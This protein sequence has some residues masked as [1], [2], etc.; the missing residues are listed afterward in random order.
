MRRSVW[1]LLVMVMITLSCSEQEEQVTRD[2][3]SGYF[4]L[5]VGDF[6]IYEVDEIQYQQNVQTH[7]VYELKTLVVDSFLNE[8]GGYTFA[9]NQFRR[10]DS[11]K[12]WSAIESASARVSNREVVVNEGNTSYV[13]MSTPLL[14][15]QKWN[16]NA[17]NNEGGDERCGTDPAYSCDNYEITSVNESFA[18][19]LATYDQALTVM[20][21]NDPDILVKYDVRKQVYASGVGLVT[22]EKTVLNY[23]TTPPAC[24]G[25]QYVDTGYKYKQILKERGVEK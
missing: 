19:A 23:C 24:Y 2:A 20:E 6:A 22:V 7:S 17:L 3:F 15:G 10:T 11:S 12:P 21:N 14:K 9:I 18:T 5:Q 16:G 25:T 1:F 13:K 4:P 8:Q